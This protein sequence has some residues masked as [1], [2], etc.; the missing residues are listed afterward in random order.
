[1]FLKELKNLRKQEAFTIPYITE[2]NPEI[3]IHHIYTPFRITLGF[4]LLFKSLQT[5]SKS[6]L[7]LQ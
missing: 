4:R 5:E 2:Q 6:L 3:L 7:L 1:M